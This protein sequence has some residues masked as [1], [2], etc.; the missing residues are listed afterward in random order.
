MG[1]ESVLEK[2]KNFNQFQKS[3]GQ[4]LFPYDKYLKSNK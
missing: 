4:A 1:I 3:Q 2:G